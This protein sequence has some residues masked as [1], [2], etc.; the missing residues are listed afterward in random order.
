MA[1]PYFAS[2][3]QTVQKALDQLRQ[4]FV[5][6]RTNRASPALLDRVRVSAYGAEMPIQQLASVSAPDSRTL[7][8]RPWDP[9]V[10]PDIEKA[11]LKSDIGVSPSSDGTVIRLVL[12]TL[13]AERRQELVKVA[14]KF[15]EDARVR[16]R[17]A[18]RDA[19][20]EA[21]NKPLKEKKIAEDEKFKRQQELDQLTTKGIAEVDQLLATK[22]KEILQV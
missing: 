4:D 15:A 2:Y 9:K 12:P 10:T 1:S 13:T 18:R 7:E 17:N 22:E 5:T 20:E 16:V 6:L 8:V 3:A 19:G 21:I 11:I 14:K